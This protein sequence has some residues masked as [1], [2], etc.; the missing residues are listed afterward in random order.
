MTDE[1]SGARKRSRIWV[2]GVVGAVVAVA[3]GAV[4]ITTLRGDSGDEGS[5]ASTART[6]AATTPSALPPAV[7]VASGKLYG[8]AWSVTAQERSGWPCFR[9]HVTLRSGRQLPA[10]CGELVGLGAAP[11]QWQTAGLDGSRI[12]LAFGTA[13]RGVAH[14]ELVYADGSRARIVPVTYH[15]TRYFGFAY[16]TDQ[17][18]HYVELVRGYDKAGRLVQ[19]KG[20]W[21][22]EGAAPDPRPAALGMPPATVGS[23]VVDGVAWR[24]LELPPRPTRVYAAA[25]FAMIDPTLVRGG[26]LTYCTLTSVGGRTAANHCGSWPP[27]SYLNPRRPINGVCSRSGV[28]TIC[29]GTVDPRVDRLVLVG[30]DGSARPLRLVTYHGH[31]FV[32]FA[33]P[34]QHPARSLIAYEGTNCVTSPEDRRSS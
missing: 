6:T 23:G 22:G 29:E 5:P 14:Y 28:P 34:T 25:G 21:S 13:A 27:S 3:G 31:R 32:A 18:G 12:V 8:R 30:S 26:S 9:V 1:S 4:A 10:G 17:I 33:F 15:G 11:G 16:A 20:P 19:S 7:T 24:I 2:A